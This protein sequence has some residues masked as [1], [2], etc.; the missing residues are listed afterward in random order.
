MKKNKFCKVHSLKH[1]PYYK[2]GICLI[3]LQKCLVLKLRDLTSH[4]Q[5][6]L[7]MTAS[8][9]KHQRIVHNRTIGPSTGI[10]L[11]NG[12]YLPTLDVNVESYQ[13][14]IE[15]I[16]ITDTVYTGY[17][18]QMRVQFLRSTHLSLSTAGQMEGWKNVCFDA[19]SLNSSF[20]DFRGIPASETSG[21]F[22]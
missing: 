16:I 12:W 20:T 7:H 21:W 19:S 2:Q 10:Q 8:R 4:R 18:I 22:I 13:K 11:L 5:I 3:K 15:P 9:A 14:Q 1:P 17:S 6:Y